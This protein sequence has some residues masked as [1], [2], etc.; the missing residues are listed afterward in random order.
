MCVYVC[1]CVC[2]GIES[3]ERENRG[4]TKACFFLPS[5]MWGVAALPTW[6]LWK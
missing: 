3:A 4:L 6:P 5:V 2:V 1:V